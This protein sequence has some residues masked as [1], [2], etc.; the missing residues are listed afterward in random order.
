LFHWI[1]TDAGD[2]TEASSDALVCL[3]EHDTGGVALWL[4]AQGHGPEQGRALAAAIVAHTVRDAYPEAE[5]SLQRPLD[6]LE[7]VLRE[8]STRLRA[9]ADAQPDLRGMACS[10]A[11]VLRAAGH[12]WV[13]HMGT[14][15]V[16]GLRGTE[17]VK[18]TRD[19]IT[20]DYTIHNEAAAARLRRDDVVER[21]IGQQGAMLDRGAGTPIDDDGMPLLLCTDCVW[22]AVPEPVLAQA[23]HRL[24]PRDACDAIIGLARAQWCEDDLTLGV[25]REGLPDAAALTSSE[26]FIAWA[27]G[28]SVSREG[29]NQ[30]L[31]IQ[32]PLRGLSHD[33]P[34]TILPH[35]IPRLALAERA[36]PPPVAAL[37]SST[38]VLIPPPVAASG[39]STDVFIPPQA[40]GASEP[41]Q[42]ERTQIFSPQVDAPR[43]IASDT[44]AVHA[45]V[46][47]GTQ[48]FAP[49]ALQGAR[50]PGGAANAP[51][52]RAARASETIAQYPAPAAAAPAVAAPTPAARQPGQRSRARDPFAERWDAGDS[53]ARAAAEDRF[54][55]DAMLD[56]QP[57][58]R[59]LRWLLWIAIA[60]ASAGGG[61]AATLWWVGR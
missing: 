32:S 43:V 26:A 31:V 61:F 19:H 28:E 41:K 56:L 40:R 59:G 47:G 13:A 25:L 55:P 18:L 22:R 50:S 11:V 30:T 38:E 9:V 33:A 53:G 48:V 58:R 8:A 34:P 52:Q 7:L 3:S 5:L 20:A 17:L 57:G 29:A 39:S 23:L 46:G 2:A 27:Q 36:P 16:Y 10:V 15:R 6:A 4:V 60:L 49:S 35:S 51:A 44:I 24:P 12:T 21:A 1:A 45:D 14:C 54:D 42:P 37:G